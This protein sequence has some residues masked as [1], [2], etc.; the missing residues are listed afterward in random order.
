MMFKFKNNNFG[1]GDVSSD[2][3]SGNA[4]GAGSS[5]IMMQRF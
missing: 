4:G 5:S 3:E 1:A 2:D